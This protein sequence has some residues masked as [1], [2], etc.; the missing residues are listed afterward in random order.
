MP[1]PQR[2]SR[3][4]KTYTGAE[5]RKRRQRAA[6]PVREWNRRGAEEI[7]TGEGTLYYNCCYVTARRRAAANPQDGALYVRRR[8]V[9]RRCITSDYRTA[10]KKIF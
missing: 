2:Y 3:A 6:R 5:L 10:N 9:W 1:A 4:R 8:R 7:N